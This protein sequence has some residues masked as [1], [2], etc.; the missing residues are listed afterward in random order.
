MRKVS[1]ILLNYNGLNFLKEC[2]P[3]IHSQTYGN[4]E[5]IVTDNGSSD[6]SQEFIRK[7]KD[8]I[9][10][11]N[12]S[13][14]GYAKANNLAARKARGHFLFFL[15][16]DTQ[17]FP[18]TIEE[19]V[20]EYEEKSILSAQQLPIWDKAIEGSAGAGMDIFGYPHIEE[21]IRK[22]KIFYADGAMFFVAK[23]DFFDI[24]MF[25]EELFIFQEDIDFS[26]RAQI[27]G[28]KIKPC[29]QAKVYH[30]GGGTV[31]GG[32]AGAKKSAK[33]VS[34]YFRRYQ[35]EKNIVR[36]I[37]KNYSFPLN[38]IILL[39]LLLIHSLEIL[40]LTLM[41][42]GKAAFCYFRAYWWNIVNLKDT[43]KFR[44]QIQ[45]RRTVSDPSLMK[46]MYWSYS[47]LY[48]LKKLGIPQFKE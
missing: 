40:I 30:Y 1:I 36:N 27:M 38:I 28:Y 13:N 8:I 6:G 12:K 10:I 5:I 46:K 45:S 41:F 43:L 21:D 20:K 29:W 17:L 11:E 25:D 22:I 7:T 9:L 15:N 16:N 32:S 37:L 3:T 44:E 2:I 18:N 26:W 31:T 24:G 35:N 48:S 14:L 4:L 42:K 19:L 33:Y 23:K 39:L 34:S 47:K